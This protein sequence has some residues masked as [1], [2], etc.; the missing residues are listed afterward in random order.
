MIVKL[1]DLIVLL[2]SKLLNCSINNIRPCCHVIVHVV[3]WVEIPVQWRIFL[4]S[5]NHG[6]RKRGHDGVVSGYS[7]STS[8]SRVDGLST[9]PLG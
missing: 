1:V 2:G 3:F 9:G 7:T 8:I 5:L 6:S 4:F